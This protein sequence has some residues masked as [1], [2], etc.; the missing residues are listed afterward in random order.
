[1][2]AGSAR[3]SCRICLEEDKRE[4]GLIAPCRCKSDRTFVH[5]KC[6]DH[7]RATK[8]GNGRAFTHCEICNFEYVVELKGNPSEERSRKYKFRALVARD[9]ILV[10]LLLQVVI[11]L[12]GLIV[13]G[14]DQPKEILRHMFPALVSEHWKTTYYICGFVLFLAILGIGG[15]CSLCCSDRRERDPCGNGHCYFWG[16]PN[17]NCNN[18]GGG[19]G[20]EC[21]VILV[22]IVVVLAFIGIFVGIF[23]SSMLIQRIIQRHYKVLWLKQET[24]KYV[25]VDFYGRD[26][27]DHTPSAPALDVASPSAPAMEME[28][29]PQQPPT[30]PKGLY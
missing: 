20:Y 10:F 28:N 11:V 27:P 25:V 5:R 3:L 16:C 23:L 14:L 19:D 24:Q 6:L 7:W 29:M 9:T 13:M 26:L 18:N 2:E 8:T 4:N 17:C 22:V 15:L 12:L 1:M 21:L 30:Y